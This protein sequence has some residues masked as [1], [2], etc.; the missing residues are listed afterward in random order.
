MIFGILL[1]TQ[2]ERIRQFADSKN[3]QRL[4]SDLREPTRLRMASL[5]DLSVEKWQEILAKVPPGDLCNVALTSPYMNSMAS[6]QGLWAGMKVNPRKVRDSGLQELFNIRRFKKIKQID[7]FG[8]KFTPEQLEKLMD[9]I[10]G[11]P[12][13]DINLKYINLSGVPAD[14]LARTV[15]HLHTVKLKSNSLSTHQCTQVLNTSITSTT[16]ADL[17]LAGNNLFGVSANILGMAV[18]RLKTV[19]LK[20][21]SLST[22]QCTQVLNTSLTST[23]LVDLNLARNNLSGVPA[24]IL[25]MAVGRLKTVNLEYT[26]LSTDQ[27]TQVLNTSITSTTLADLNLAEN[28]L[29]GVLAELLATA[30]G[31]LQTVNLKDTLLST[32]QCTKI[33]ETIPSSTT[34]ADLN[35]A[36]NNLSGVPAD[37]LAM[38]VGRLKNVDFRRTQLTTNQCV[39]V[40]HAITSSATLTDLDFWR[41]NLSGVPADI[42]ALAVSRLKTVNLSN[43]RLTTDQCV[44]VLDAIPSIATLTNLYMYGID[45]SG[46]PSDLLAKNVGRLK[47]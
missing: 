14:K 34:L 45:L 42:L 13:E 27:C 12:L 7:F 18:G 17:N 26:R 44:K 15:G 24:N 6:Y 4:S 8:V 36:V 2:F 5:F 39:E 37:I 30:V 20:F 35:L 31:H 3:H 25:G 1:C 10:P 11:F 33:L 9:D 22:D 16:L 29:F 28:N 41:I 32:V 43:T 19:N 23:T 46:V 21:T 40:L 38:A 47:I